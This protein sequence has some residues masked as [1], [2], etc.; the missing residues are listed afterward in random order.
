LA[1][2]GVSEQR[3]IIETPP[4][5]AFELS[6]IGRPSVVGQPS[7]IDVDEPNPDGLELPELNPL[8]IPEPPLSE[9][10]PESQ[11][12]PELRLNYRRS[13]SAP[14][15]ALALVDRRSI[16]PHQPAGNESPL[17]LALPAPD[18]GPAGTPSQDMRDRYAVGDFTGALA[19]AEH[20]I[21]ERPADA[22]AQRVAEDCRKVL[23]DMYLARLGSLNH[24][25]ILAIPREEVRWLSLDHRSGF[26]LS[27][28]DG[29]LTVEEV[30]DVCGMPQ[31]EA[32]RILLALADQKVIGLAT[33]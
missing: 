19:A 14:R 18:V 9:S 13:Y 25:I 15:N 28:V 4:P 26:L 21:G 23:T 8:P 10:D 17:D 1:F 22:E 11:G 3:P 32:L 20:L 7:V 27:L 30:L 24:I 12:D 33:R 2:G 16:P 29:R 5:E 6:A 31:L